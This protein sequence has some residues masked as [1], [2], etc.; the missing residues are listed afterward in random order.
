MII[1]KVI[2]KEDF[3]F[4]LEDTFLEKPQRW[5]GRRSFQIDPTPGVKVLI[6]ILLK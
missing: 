1:L 4:S 5:R 6:F 3:T 2:Q